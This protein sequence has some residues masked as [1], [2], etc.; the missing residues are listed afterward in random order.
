MAGHY[1][2]EMT[3]EEWI[4]VPDHPRQRRTDRRA[5]YARTRHLKV[6]SE[7]HSCVEAV[8]FPRGKISKLNGHTRAFLWASNDLERPKGKL[9]VTVFR[10]ANRAEFL[11]LYDNYDSR[12]AVKQNRDSLEGAF[13]ELGIAIRSPLLNQFGFTTQLRRAA[14]D[15]KSSIYQVAESWK[16]E[17]VRL[18]GLMMSDNFKFLVRVALKAIRRDGIEKAGP[19]FKGIDNGAGTRDE[20]WKDGIQAAWEFVSEKKNRKAASGWDNWNEIDC[21]VWS[22]YEQYLARRKIKTQSPL[23]ASPNIELPDNPR[24][25]R[26]QEPRDLT[27]P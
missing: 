20:G 13:N 15:Q 26:N 9:T 17:V 18:D 4:N 23:R 16:D 11:G 6:L 27:C 24:K 21:K 12:F 8:E 10:V 7:S 1:V 2:T 14:N 22:G 25:Q 3:V 19:F 5:N